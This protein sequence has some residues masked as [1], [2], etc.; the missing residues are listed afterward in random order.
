ML[1]ALRNTKE[2]GGKII[3]INPLPEAGLITFKDPQ[4]PKDWISKGTTLSDIH[5][6]KESMVT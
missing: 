5:L 6:P 4:R 1:S 3:C 2:N